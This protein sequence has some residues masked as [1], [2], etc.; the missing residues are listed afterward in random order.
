MFSEIPKD[1]NN[2][3]WN[4]RNK[5]HNWKN[6]ASSELQFIWNGFTEEQKIIISQNLN[7]LAGILEKNI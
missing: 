7:S 1:Y 4:D 6:Y 3:D 2:P 5:V